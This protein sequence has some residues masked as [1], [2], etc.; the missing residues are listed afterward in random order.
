MA[1]LTNLKTPFLKRMMRVG[2]FRSGYA[3]FGGYAK[4][5]SFF[6]ASNHTCPAVRLTI[7]IVGFFVG[8][9]VRGRF[10]VRKWF[11]RP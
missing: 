10:F 3:V 5:L 11:P 1:A 7:N 9:R 4:R 2:F 6:S 8:K